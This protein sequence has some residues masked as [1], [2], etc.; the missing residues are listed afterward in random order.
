MIEVLKGHTSPETAVVVDDYPYGF[1]LRCK[2]RY[3]LECNEKR[4]FRFVSQTTNPKKGFNG[5]S[6]QPF[7]N[8]PKASTYTFG[9][10]VML[11]DDSNGHV[12]YSGIRF[13][14]CSAA[15]LASFLARHR[16]AL[17][18]IAI[19]AAERYIR[20]KTEYEKQKEA[21]LDYRVA[22][23]VAVVK[24]AKGELVKQEIDPTCVLC[25]FNEGP[26]DH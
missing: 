16:D 6:G 11:R 24:E 7:W 17:P 9:L 8:K 2:I 3:W 20:V 22:A 15:E 10:C 26:H 18:A 12:T 13:D 25:E 19:T 23:H 14:N 5:M 1:R 4:G 21:G